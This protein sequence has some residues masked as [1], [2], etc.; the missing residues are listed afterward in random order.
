ME[1]LAPCNLFPG[2]G[3]QKKLVLLAV[4]MDGLFIRW[5]MRGSQGIVVCTSPSSVKRSITAL[6]CQTPRPPQQHEALDCSDSRGAGPVQTSSSS[7]SPSTYTPTSAT[8]PNAQLDNVYNFAYNVA[9]ENLGSTC[10]RDNVQIRR[11]WYVNRS[12]IGDL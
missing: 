6:A 3:I 10:T 2:W 7:Y 9:N 1:G 11:E 4:R 5:F 8:D 12:G